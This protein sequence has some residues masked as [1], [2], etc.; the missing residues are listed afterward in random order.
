MI[1][2]IIGI[3]HIYWH[4]YHISYGIK[5]DICHNN[6]VLKETQQI[7]GAQIHLLGSKV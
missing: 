4:Y 5:K 2:S 6:K 7:T 3:W 1:I